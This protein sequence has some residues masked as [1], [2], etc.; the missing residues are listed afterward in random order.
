[1]LIAID[2]LLP[3]NILSSLHARI[4]ADTAAIHAREAER[5]VDEER[6]R[7]RDDHAIELEII[8]LAARSPSKAAEII[9]SLGSLI[10]SGLPREARRGLLDFA[11]LGPDVV[12]KV[13]GAAAK[14]VDSFRR[15][16]GQAGVIMPPDSIHVVVNNEGC[17]CKAG[18]SGRCVLTPTG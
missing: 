6:E 9:D 10:G 7:Q 15:D 17:A 18:M 2:L 4:R 3:P 8:A 11:S 1:M 16:A 5:R 12:E 13:G 14:L